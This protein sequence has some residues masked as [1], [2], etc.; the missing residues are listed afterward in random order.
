MNTFRIRKRT[1]MKGG[2]GGERGWDGTIWTNLTKVKMT[3]I[4]GNSNRKRNKYTNR[5]KKEI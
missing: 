1:D 5:R 3:S 2:E 4:E